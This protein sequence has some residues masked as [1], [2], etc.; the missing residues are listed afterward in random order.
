M[1]LAAVVLSLWTATAFAESISSALGKIVATE[2]AFAQTSVRHGHRDAFLA[3]LA[4]DGIT[5]SP[6]VA[7]GPEGIRKRPPARAAAKLNWSA[8]LGGVSRG[9]DLGFTTGPW[10]V[11]DRTGQKPARHGMYLTIW[12]RQADGR[13]LVDLDVGI[14]TPEA[15]AHLDALSFT[16]AP[17]VGHGVPE[18]SRPR[19]SSLRAAD[20]RYNQ[21][22][23]AEGWAKAAAGVHRDDAR[24]HIDRIGPLEPR[25]AAEARLRQEPRTSLTSVGY[26]SSNDRDLGYTYGRYENGWYVRLWT[27]QP[28]TPWKIFIETL[29][30]LPPR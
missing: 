19:R 6:S 23:A 2:R 20:V 12:R 25:A 8:M 13:Y 7:R 26:R 27:R 14:A 24:L 28:A 21:A 18:R 15:V 10:V 3:Y 1:R 30:P 16:E 17:G 29:L 5:F 4:D 11:T 9:G 22:I